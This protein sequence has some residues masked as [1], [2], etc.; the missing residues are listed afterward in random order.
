MKKLIFSIAALMFCAPV[1]ARITVGAERMN[2]YLPLLEGRRVGVVTNHTGMV[3]RRHLVDTLLARKV[4]VELVFAPEHGFRGTAAAGE[5]VDSGRDAA[6]GLEIVSLYGAN[7]KPRPEQ[8]RR[9]DV[10]L[11]DI[12]DVGCRFYTYLS[13]MHLVMEACAA[14]GVPFVVLDRPNPNSPMG[15]DGP[16][17]DVERHRSFVGMHPIPVLHGMTLGELARMIN[18]ERWTAGLRQCDLTVIECEGWTRNMTYELPVAP[19]PALPNMRAVRLYP[20]LCFFEATAVSVGRGGE[21]PFQV[22][23]HPDG[24][25]VDLRHTPS[26]EVVVAAGIDLAWLID[27]YREVGDTPGGRKFLSTFFENLMG[28]D[29]V[30]TM[31]ESGATADEIR[32]RW[33]P[34]VARFTSQRK[35]YL[36]YE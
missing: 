36:I 33:A 28:V 26:D 19:S 14:E 13:T 16:L 31:I 4:R 1:S 23:T 24:M 5:H 20:S 27:A 34:D 3:G 29:W 6:T 12:Q 32:A 17:L 9:C 18:G 25:V 35:P 22:L 15:V 2:A 21:A 11:F 7:R 10:V 30:R 8:I